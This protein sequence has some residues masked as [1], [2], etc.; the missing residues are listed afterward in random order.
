[1]VQ[2]RWQ[3][4]ACLGIYILASVVMGRDVLAHLG[5]TIANDAGDPILT[6]TILHWVATHVPYTDAWYQFPIFY[7]SRDTLTFSEH[8]LGVSVIAAPIE[9]LTGSPVVAYNLTLVASFALSAAAMFALA[10]RL[11]GSV[12][13]SFIAGLAYGF[14][15]YRISQLP[16]IQM[17]VLWY[18]PLAVLGLHAYLE[19]GRRRWL[20]LYGV[21]WMLQGAANGYA[22]VFLSVLIGV[23]LL[24]FVVAA[25][26]MARPGVH[27]GD[28]GCRRAAAGAHPPAVHPCAPST[29]G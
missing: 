14:N 24:W 3:V 29:T 8:L 17:E 15:P 23:W 28:D 10:W 16:H 19:T 27:R 1:M 22:L 5:D 26:T 9:W 4:A 18:A 20:A 7:P 12:P 11:T 25:R 13:A 6:T 21:C 2:R